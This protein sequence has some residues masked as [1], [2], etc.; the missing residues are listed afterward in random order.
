MKIIPLFWQ[1]RDRYH[2][3]RLARAVFGSTTMGT[4]FHMVSTVSH[5]RSAFNGLHGTI[6]RK[7]LPQDCRGRGAFRGIFAQT[8]IRLNRGAAGLFAPHEQ[9]IAPFPPA[10]PKPMPS[11]RFVR[12][13]VCLDASAATMIWCGRYSNVSPLSPYSADETAGRGRC[14]PRGASNS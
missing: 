7:R 5:L 3:A 9:F 2:K 10:P 1:A 12:M 11:G 8:T 4:R 14:L 13:Q 6:P